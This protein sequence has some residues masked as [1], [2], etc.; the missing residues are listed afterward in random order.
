MICF[1]R[2]S[3]VKFSPTSALL[4]VVFVFLLSMRLPAQIAPGV[5]DID[6]IRQNQRVTIYDTAPNTAVIVVHTFAEEK[7]TNLD[8]SAR[9]DLANLGNHLGVSQ[10]VRGRDEAVFVNT[11]LG[12]YA[13]SVTAVG[14]ISA[15][16]EISVLSP[17]KQ[18]IDIVLHRDP[19]AITLN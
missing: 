5:Q 16:Q 7:P 14:Y 15:S 6:A 10:I 9:V 13:I 18:E 12:R 11:A 2:R 8:R 3:T 4:S 17:V 1:V 19:A